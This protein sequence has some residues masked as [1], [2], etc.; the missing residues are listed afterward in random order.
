MNEIYA[1]GPEI[2]SYCVA[3]FASY[4]ALES[5][6]RIAYF[7]GSHERLWLLVGGVIMGTGIS[8]TYFIGMTTARLGVPVTY[9]L[10]LAALAWAVAVSSSTLALHII[11]RSKLSAGGIVAGAAVMGIG[12]CAMDYSGGW[13][14]LMTPGLGYQPLPSAM[15]IVIGMAA[16]TAALFLNFSVQ[17]LPTGRVVAP[18]VLAA[19]LMGVASSGAH[20]TAMASTRFAVGAGSAAGHALSGNWASP[21]AGLFVIALAIMMMGLSRMDVRAVAVRCRVGRERMEA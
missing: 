11:S 7:D 10:G 8:L 14:M 6:G 13:A 19:L 20:S 12:I 21:L 18:R 3:I 9:D 16:L 5:G 1:L 17:H 15:S 4:V 2:A